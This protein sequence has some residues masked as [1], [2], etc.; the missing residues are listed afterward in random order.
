M[1]PRQP[2]GP[3]PS[4]LSDEEAMAPVVEPARQIVRAAGLQD[5]TGGFA[6]ESC[7]DQGAPPFRGRVEMSF[8]VPAGVEPED[9]FKGIAVTMVE[10]GWSDGP[11][12]GTCPAGVVIHTAT[13]MAIIGRAAAVGRGSVQL[14]GACRNMTNHR[15]DGKTVGTVITDQLR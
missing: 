9:Y 4:L 2:D 15:Y 8:A 13:V 3:E 5:V 11:P 7:N 6:F 1:F 14:C 10:Q 12:P